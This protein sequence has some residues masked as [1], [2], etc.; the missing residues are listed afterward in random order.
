MGGRDERKQT[1]AQSIKLTNMIH[2]T[3]Y[4]DQKTTNWNAPETMGDTHIPTT[5]RTLDWDT[6]EKANCL[7]LLDHRQAVAISN[8]KESRP[9]RDFIESPICK[10]ADGQKEE[11]ETGK[12]RKNDRRIYKV[13]NR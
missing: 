8:D 2:C 9:I 5:K 13:D 1:S 11:E 7:T 4:Y 6:P 3:H 12:K 10:I